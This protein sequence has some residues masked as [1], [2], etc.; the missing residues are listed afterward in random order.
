MLSYTANFFTADADI[1]CPACAEA[2]YGEGIYTE[3]GALDSEGNVVHP[4]YSW[5]TGEFDP[6][7]AHAC[8]A[9]G[10]ELIEQMILPAPAPR[11][12]DRRDIALDLVMIMD[13]RTPVGARHRDRVAVYEITYA[14]GATEFVTWTVFRDGTCGEGAY[15][16]AEDYSDGARSARM[17]ALDELM[18][19]VTGKSPTRTPQVYA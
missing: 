8:A 4:V 6:H 1:Y 18:H 17:Y 2:A 16:H 13:A 19:R 10:G 15:Y 3:G 9:C 7:S 11:M 12:G 5:D 14:G